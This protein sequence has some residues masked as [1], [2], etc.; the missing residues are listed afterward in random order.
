MLEH[1]SFAAPISRP[2]LRCLRKTM[3][4]SPGDRRAT[5]EI[6]V[7]GS[8]YQDLAE[9]TEATTALRQVSVREQVLHDLTDHE[10]R[11]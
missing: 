4:S 8:E 1:E 2:T 3:F 10:R 9:R 6:G 7:A 5:R 11:D